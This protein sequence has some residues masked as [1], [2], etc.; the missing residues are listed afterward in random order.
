MVAKA[1][2]LTYFLDAYRAHYGFESEFAA[3]IATGLALSAVY[4]A[5]A[6]WAFLAAI[7]GRAA[8][9]SF[10]RCPSD[11]ARGS[12]ASSRRSYLGFLLGLQ[13]ATDRTIWSGGHDS[14]RASAASSTGR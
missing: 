5:L 8:R 2:P 3:P 12:P 9:G 11:R 7:S 4:A 1:I 6:H 10:S 14:S 13:H